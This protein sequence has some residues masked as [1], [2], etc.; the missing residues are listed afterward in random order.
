M[1]EEFL[2]LIK[3]IVNTCE[4][5]WQNVFFSEMNFEVGVGPPGIM[6]RCGQ[7]HVTHEW[8]FVVDGVSAQ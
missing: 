2:R 8:D 7:V 6:C 5:E 4:E 3:M 1:I